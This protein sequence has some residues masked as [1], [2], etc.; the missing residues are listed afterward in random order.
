MKLKSLRR[1]VRI[2]ASS[3]TVLS[4]GIALP[5]LADTEARLDGHYAKFQSYGDQFIVTAPY[6]QS[7]YVNWYIPSTKRSGTCRSEQSPCNY[8][9]REKRIIQWQLCHF[10]PRQCTNT[11]TDNTS[12]P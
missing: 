11:K 8:N 2:G 1:M 7:G 4:V 10:L 5:A 9:F 6:L 3:I 12:L